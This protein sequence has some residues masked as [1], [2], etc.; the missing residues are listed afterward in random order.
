MRQAEPVGIPVKAIVFGNSYGVLTT[1]PN[2]KPGMFA[3]P[4]YSTTGSAL[5]GHHAGT[6]EAAELK[7]GSSGGYGCCVG[8]D[9]A[10]YVGGINPG[11][12]YR[13]SLEH[14]A[15]EDVG[16]SQF[17]ASYIWDTTASD[18]GKVY[19]ACYP[20]CSVIEYD[21]KSQSL[22]DLG[23]VQPNEQY[24][25][26]ICVDHRGKVW[27]GVGTHA[28]LIVL[29]PETGERHDVLPRA[30]QSNSTCY[31]IAASSR[32][33]LCSILYAGELLIFN[34][35][36]ETLVR[37]V[38]PP[39]DGLSWK[40]SRGARPGEAY[41]YALPNG[42]LYH[43]DIAADKLSPLAMGLG[44]CAYVE[45]DR[46]VHGISDQDYFVYDLRTCRFTATRKL[47]EAGDGMAVY[48]LTGHSDGKIY[49]S[50][51]INQ[52]LFR[53]DPDE[54]ELTDLGKVIRGG[55]QVDSIHSGRDGR[56]YL[57]SYARGYLSVYDPATAWRP[58][59]EEHSNPRELGRVGHGQYRT[60]AIA[61][62]PAGNIWVG[63]IPSYNSAPSGAFSRWDPRTGEHQSWLDLVPG[64]AVDHIAAGDRLLY[65]AGGGVLFLWD[66]VELTK[67]AEQR[68]AV[69]AMVR[70][71]TGHLVVSSD[72]DLLVF[73][74]GRLDVVSTCSSPIGAMT[75]MTV[76][77]TGLICGIN[78]Q[79]IAEM[80]PADGTAR[81]ISA[82]GGS[83][84]AAD[85]NGVLYFARGSQ[86]FRLR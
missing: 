10:V 46:Y 8:S 64:G 81:R 62:G 76:T 84:L 47:T 69:S 86:L 18:N 32:Y 34:A 35:Q 2:G 37:A 22:R 4:Y 39:P 36:T 27:V 25:R 7:L 53:H 48:T 1:S 51:Y 13:C 16:G 6:S 83:F 12:L 66:P 57:G 38:P 15:V 49:G 71:A 29:D 61:L 79:G 72:A 26:A 85:R 3:I 23:R 21:I 14:G 40:I 52:H 5:V 60:R 17:G 9:G 50:T 78:K 43:Y 41:L 20:T 74:P 73:A 24:A 75:A 56:L 33:V 55:G 80:S 44:Q 19:G 77:P 58:G 31:D 45:D 42:D 30:Y 63:T 54:G 59:T 28:H 65:C 82:P 11:N 67:V 70:T 68:R